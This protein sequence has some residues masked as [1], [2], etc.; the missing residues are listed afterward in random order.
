MVQPTYNFLRR[1]SK[2]IAVILDCSKAF[3]LAKFNIIFSELLDRGVPAIVVR[4]LS[5]SYQEQQAWV[6]W[7]R[8]ATS[9]TFTI[10]NGTRQ[11]SV[12]SPSFWSIYLNPLFEKLRAAGIGCTVEQMW[13]GIVGYADDIILLAPTRSAAQRMLCICENLQAYTT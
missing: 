1:G 3:D 8:K 7:D 10:R 2:P 9:S 12:A 6:K 5:F 13:I 11:G 4:V